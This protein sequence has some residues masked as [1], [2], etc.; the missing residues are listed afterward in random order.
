MAL[1]SAAAAASARILSAYP[2]ADNV[3]RS[4]FR[5]KVNG[6]FIGNRVN[7]TGQLRNV[8]CIAVGDV[9]RLA[10]GA[11]RQANVVVLTAKCFTIP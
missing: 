7:A 11:G 8:L 5:A 4:R 6:L 1:V 10:S 2:R 9:L 3:Y